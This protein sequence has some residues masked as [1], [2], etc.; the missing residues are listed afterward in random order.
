MADYNESEV[1]IYQE[2]FT[3]HTVHGF[4]VNVQFILS[5][6]FQDLDNRPIFH[7]EVKSDLHEGQV[8]AEYNLKFVHQMCPTI[9]VNVYNDM[10]SRNSL[11]T[12]DDRI[13]LF[14]GQYMMTGHVEFTIKPTRSEWF[15]LQFKKVSSY[16]SNTSL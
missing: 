15:M 12:I 10:V 9:M 6:E 16:S 14:D 11:Y 8:F 3:I 13:R 5:Y 4:E 7:V 2:Q 1:I